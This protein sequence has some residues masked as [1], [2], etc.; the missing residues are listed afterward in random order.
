MNPKDIQHDSFLDVY[1]VTIGVE[2]TE[3]RFIEEDSVSGVPDDTSV[4]TD[5]LKDMKDRIQGSNIP[6]GKVIV[7]DMMMGAHFLIEVI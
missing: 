4:D 5:K 7:K 1:S 3:D 6:D 2:G